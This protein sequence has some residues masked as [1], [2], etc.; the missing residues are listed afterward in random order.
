MNCLSRFQA[1]HAVGVA[2]WDSFTEAQRAFATTTPLQ[3][4]NS[5]SVAEAEALGD[6][7]RFALLYAKRRQAA[8]EADAAR[9]GWFAG[10]AA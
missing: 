3:K 6:V 10:V 7:G 9:L 2:A 8:I 1:Q 4:L 5:L